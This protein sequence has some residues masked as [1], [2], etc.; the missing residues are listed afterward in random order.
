MDRGA[1]LGRGRRSSIG[2]CAGT[3]SA[4]GEEPTVRQSQIVMTALASRLESRVRKDAF[5]FLQKLSEDDA[6][7]GLHIEPVKNAI[8]PKVRTGRVNQQYRAVLFKLV[9]SDMP[10]Y[11]V[12]G[13]FNHDDAYVEAE[14]ATLR[15]NPVNG[16]AEIRVIDTATEPTAAT[17]PQVE[18]QPAEREPE[19]KVDR[20]R[21]E[22]VLTVSAE[23]L[24]SELG[25]PQDVARHVVT[26]DDAALA[27][28]VDSQPEWVADALLDLATGGTLTEVIA[29]FGA[30]RR[31]TERPEDE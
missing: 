20:T 12:H 24:E 31:V 28:Y 19:P 29:R 21:A 22:P 16:I 14:R 6:I 30:K 9:G 8:D 5:A 3:G 7:P 17:T 10:T 2:R 26:L 4:G 13:I 1:R 15:V 11:V 18:T 25:I 23:S 27:G